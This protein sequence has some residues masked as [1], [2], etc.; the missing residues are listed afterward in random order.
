MT[1]SC[2]SNRARA[3]LAFGVVAA[4]AIAGSVFFVCRKLL[5]VDRTDV[6][7]LL[8][9]S[10]ELAGNKQSTTRLMPA[11]ESL[12]GHDLTGGPRHLGLV[13]DNEL[14]SPYCHAEVVLEL[15]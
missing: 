11:N 7:S 3:A 4:V 6:A 15:E 5:R 10:D 13:V 9:E 14:A 8:G 12:D 1:K 2:A